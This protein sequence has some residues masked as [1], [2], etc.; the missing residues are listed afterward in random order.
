MNIHS[1]KSSDLREVEASPIFNDQ[2]GLFVAE[3]G[4][5]WARNEQKYIKNEW[6]SL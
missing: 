2:N 4:L 3:N 1:S 5:E 6:L